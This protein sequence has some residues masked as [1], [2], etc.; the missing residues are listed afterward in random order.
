MVV[1]CLVRI[2]PVISVGGRDVAK[3]KRPFNRLKGVPKETDEYAIKTDRRPFVFSMTFEDGGTVASSGCVRK[4]DC[5]RLAEI[6]KE[7]H[8]LARKP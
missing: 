7:I 2:K 5:D 4:E 8:E 3:S 6:F 1:S